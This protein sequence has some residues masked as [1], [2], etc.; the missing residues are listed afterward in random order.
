MI[1]VDF[2]FLPVLAGVN[3]AVFY[4]LLLCSWF[5]VVL[6]VMF[7][8]CFAVVFSV[9]PL[10]FV[11]WRYVIGF[12]S[13]FLPFFCHCIFGFAILFSDLPSSF[14]ICRYVWCFAIMF[15]ICRYALRLSVMF[16]D[17]LLCFIFR[18]V[19]IYK[20][21]CFMNSLFVPLALED[22]Q[23][24]AIKFPKCI[25]YYLIGY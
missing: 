7:S 12:A 2:L 10:C 3:V 9:L 15:V 17:L 8:V 23:P 20:N 13:F 5:S 14:V 25:I 19:S 11:I 24:L 22:T 4:D 1:F 21:V 18:G 16:C 6:A